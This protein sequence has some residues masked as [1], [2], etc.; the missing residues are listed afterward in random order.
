MMITKLDEM[1]R[2]YEAEDKEKR[3]FFLGKKS[4]WLNENCLVKVVSEL[5]S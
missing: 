1:Q 2:K 3:S 4:L 5:E